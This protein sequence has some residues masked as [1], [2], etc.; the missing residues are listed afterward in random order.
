MSGPS[1]APATEHPGSTLELPDG[2][3]PEGLSEHEYAE[4]VQRIESVFTGQALGEIGDR[5]ADEAAADAPGRRRSGAALVVL[6]NLIS[7]ALLAGGIA[8]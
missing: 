3:R 6:V 4:I 1:A 5:T 2:P 7:F 8:A